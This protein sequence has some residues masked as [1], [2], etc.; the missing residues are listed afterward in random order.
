M[1][2]P[3]GTALDILPC[4]SRLLNNMNKKFKNFN[5]QIYV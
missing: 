4:S 1:T 5:N 3:R 2:D